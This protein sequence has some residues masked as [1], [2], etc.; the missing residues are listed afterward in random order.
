M[1]GLEVEL[2][3]ARL[4]VSVLKQ[5]I[6]AEA[7]LTFLDELR[8]EDI[9]LVNFEAEMCAHDALTGYRQ[10]HDLLRAATENLLPQ[11]L[12]EAKLLAHNDVLAARKL[13][14]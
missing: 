1:S 5:A 12:G 13:I 6:D 4:R 3:V 11:I 8:D 2:E 9:A 10:A 14:S 7:A